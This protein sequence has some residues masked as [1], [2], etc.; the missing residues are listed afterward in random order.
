VKERLQ[1]VEEGEVLGQ[2]D[3]RKRHVRSFI[4]RHDVASPGDLA[5]GPC[6]FLVAATYCVVIVYIANQQSQSQ[7]IKLH[8]LTGALEMYIPL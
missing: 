8:R 2:S 1:L 7:P 5:D 4:G 6:A 3:R